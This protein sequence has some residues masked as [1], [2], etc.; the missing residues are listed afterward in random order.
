MTFSPCSTA[1]RTRSNV[2]S[3]LA[4]ASFC[5]AFV[6]SDRRSVR[7]RASL[8]TDVPDRRARSSVTT[9]RI[10]RAAIPA[11]TV[12]G[13]HVR[14]LGGSDSTSSFARRSIVPCSCTVSSFR[15][16]APS[17]FQPYCVF[18]AA[19]YRFANDRKLRPSGWPASCNR[20]KRSRG[21]FVSGVPVSR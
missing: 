17:V 10:S 5:R 13:N 20:T 11:A 4:T 18:S 6:S 8:A 21:R 12:V 19:Q 2:V 3:I 7:D 1:P 9:S 14:N 15:F 16:E